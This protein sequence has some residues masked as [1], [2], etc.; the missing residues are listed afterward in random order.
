MTNQDSTTNTSPAP[1]DTK[2]PVSNNG[3]IFNITL[4]VKKLIRRLDYKYVIEGLGGNWPVAILPISGVFTAESKT[5]N[6]NIAAIFCPNETICPTNS[7]NILPHTKSYSIG[8]EDKFLFTIL[9]AKVSELNSNTDFLYSEEVVVNCKNCLPDLEPK[10][11]MPSTITLNKNT[12]NT[13][14]ITASGSGMTP[15][16]RYNYNWNIMSNSWP[17]QLHPVIGTVK[18]TEDTVEVSTQIVFCETSG[19]SQIICGSPRDPMATIS[20]AL[21]SPLDNSQILSNDLLIKCDDCLHGPEI[22]LSTSSS[23]VKAGSLQEITADISGVIPYRSYRYNLESINSNWPLS[24][25]HASGVFMPLSSDAHKIQFL[26]TVCESRCRCPSE[27]NVLEYW[28]ND[29]DHAYMSFRLK[30]IDTVSNNTYYSDIKILTL[31]CPDCLLSN[32]GLSLSLPSSIVLDDQTK[33]HVNFTTSIKGLDPDTSY[34]YRFHTSEKTWPAYIYPASG[35]IRNSASADMDIVSSIVFCENSNVIDTDLDDSFIIASIDP[36]NNTTQ[37]LC[38]VSRYKKFN[39]NVSIEP[40]TSH[41]SIPDDLGKVYSNIASV[42]CDDCIV[43]PK[44]KLFSDTVVDKNTDISI[45]ANIKDLAKDRIYTYELQNI[46]SNWPVLINKMSGVLEATGDPVNLDISAKWCKSK[47]LCPSGNLGVLDYRVNN[48][49]LD[50]NDR[51][52]VRLKITDTLLSGVY[53]SNTQTINCSGCRTVSLPN[54]VSKNI[55]DL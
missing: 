26:S 43:F 19:N 47:S 33:N 39:L 13:A 46:D 4:P 20:L 41:K 14:F 53:Y 1:T 15:G 6:I 25:D 35:I 21:T 27:E 30:L 54:I 42:M 22:S 52:T 40:L 34:V 45:S 38:G 17:I 23:S 12:G 55:T 50:Y 36:S 29:N 7:T 51:I 48:T 37:R 10:L 24:L 5:A 44:V 49:L 3:H 8:S 32:D 9:R 31:D 28:T 11:S 18:G 16:I 2:P